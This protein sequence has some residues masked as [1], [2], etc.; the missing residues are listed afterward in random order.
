MFFPPQS[1]VRKME[2]T[3]TNNQDRPEKAVKIVDCG[4]ISVAE[5]FS[6]AK[7]DAADISY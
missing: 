5:P 2:S 7:E 4:T 3:P 6:V 1:I